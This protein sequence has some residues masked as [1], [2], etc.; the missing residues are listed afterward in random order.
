M[1]SL[2]PL[3]A[4]F[5]NLNSNS[6]RRFPMTDSPFCS[7][8]VQLVNGKILVVGGTDQGLD[9]G[10]ADGRFNVRVVTPGANPSY[11]IVAV[12]PP[13]RPAA[14]DPNSGARWYPSLATMVDGN[15]LIVSGETQEGNLLSERRT[16]ISDSITKLKCIF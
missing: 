7:G 16:E 4:A 14:E 8:H 11:N 12:M 3:I 9:T 2:Q 1:I 6:Y 13:N 5:Y 10:F 15:I